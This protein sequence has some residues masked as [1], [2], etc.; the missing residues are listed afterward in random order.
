MCVLCSIVDTVAQQL[1]KAGKI[2][3]LCE[4]NDFFTRLTLL[5]AQF[6][7]ASVLVHKQGQLPPEIAAL[8]CS[9]QLMSAACQLLGGAPACWSEGFL[10]YQYS[11]MTLCS[12]E[13]VGGH[14]VWNIRCKTPHQEQAT[15]PWHQVRIP[16]HSRYH[17]VLLGR[18]AR[19]QRRF[20]I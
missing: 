7:N 9:P 16:T 5:E 14:P 19:E 10:L 8:W 12:A 20:D 2:T 17:P 11:A 13:D 18:C 6:P 4:G 15:V 1:F 3:D